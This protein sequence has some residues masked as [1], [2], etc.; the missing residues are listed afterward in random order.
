MARPEARPP[1]QR[2]VRLTPLR[3]QCASCGERLW[4]ADHAER[5]FMT[6]GIGSAHPGGGRRRNP[7]R[8]SYHAPIQQKK[9]EPGLPDGEFGLDM[10]TVIGQWRDGRASQYP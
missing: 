10:I 5:T 8:V 1:A 7:E 6:S 4:V 3:E 2:E 9:K